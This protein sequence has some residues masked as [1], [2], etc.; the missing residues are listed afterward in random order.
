TVFMYVN[1]QPSVTMD[2]GNPANVSTGAPVEFYFSGA[3]KD[4]DPDLLSYRWLFSLD[5]SPTQA[6]VLNPDSLFAR[7]AFTPS[8]VGLHTLTVWARDASG[9][10]RE[11]EPA[12]FQ[13]RVDPPAEAGLAPGP[14][15]KG[16][17]R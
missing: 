3:D 7:R 8:E 17:D 12:V 5:S 11:S 9:A 2:P 14:V 13:F 6:V 1:F 16:E 4:S 15:K 10:T